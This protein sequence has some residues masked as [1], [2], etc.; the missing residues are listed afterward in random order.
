MSITVVV[1]YES[2]FGSTRQI[3]ESIASGMGDAKVLVTCVGEAGSDFD[4]VDLLIAG[5]P[6]HA[7]SLSRPQT[8][9]QA[10][11]WAL[12]PKLHLT[13]EP[14]AGGIGVREWLK[15]L[16]RAPNFI[17]AFDTRADVPEIFSGAAGRKIERTLKKLGGE[18][19]SEHTSYLVD[20]ASQ[21]IPGQRELARQWGA[22]L[23]RRVRQ[24]VDPVH[25][26]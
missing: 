23:S 1:V 19:V 24:Q 25:A 17:A 10:A 11:A 21:L 3:A 7:H 5:A 22:E 4:D 16:S 9:Q 12:D 8:R 13:L 6:T 26:S 18:A 14:R 2:M 20:K 15:G